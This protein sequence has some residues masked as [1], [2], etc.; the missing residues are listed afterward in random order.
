MVNYS[1]ARV[2]NASRY[3]NFSTLVCFIGNNFNYTLATDFIGI[4]NA[5][6][7]ANDSV[8][9]SYSIWVLSLYRSVF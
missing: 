1:K 7:N 9:H 5:E 8:P 4:C 3:W 2:E 6:L